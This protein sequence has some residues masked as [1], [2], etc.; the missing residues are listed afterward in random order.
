MQQKI[1]YT[2]KLNQYI[3]LHLAEMP[4]LHVNSSGSE[5]ATST[6]NC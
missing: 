5:W 2:G 1:Q 3:N 4:H 6:N